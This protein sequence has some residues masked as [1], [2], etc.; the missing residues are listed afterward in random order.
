MNDTAQETTI[1]MT[2]LV[3]HEHMITP[4]VG[5]N[6]NRARSGKT[7]NETTSLKNSYNYIVIQQDS[8]VHTYNTA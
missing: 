4:A 8:I 1:A 7:R 2:V 6:E 5:N 3:E